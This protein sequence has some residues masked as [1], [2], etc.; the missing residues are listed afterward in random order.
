MRN[1]CIYLIVG[2]VLLGGCSGYMLQSGKRSF[3]TESTSA[4]GYNVSFCGNAYMNKNEAEKLTMQ[5][6]CEITLT[7]GYTHFVVLKKT[8]QSEFCSFEDLPRA[9]SKQASSNSLVGPQ[10]IVRPNI[11]LNIQCYKTKDAPEGAIDA[12]KYLDENFPGL[13]F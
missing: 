2:S 8:D 11:T 6:A 9:G 4:S 3:S 10:N 7:K 5:R 12:Q 1:F 13:K